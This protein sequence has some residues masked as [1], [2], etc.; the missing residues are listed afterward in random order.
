MVVLLQV[1]RGAII[2]I[3]EDKD[4][5]ERQ[6]FTHEHQEKYHDWVASPIAL[7]ESLHL[8]V[9]CILIE[10]EEQSVEVGEWETYQHDKHLWI[11]VAVN[12]Y[13]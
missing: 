1:N 13:I 3:L 9:I 7:T 11:N 10:I 4:H 2:K 5:Q 8:A 12:L 6:A